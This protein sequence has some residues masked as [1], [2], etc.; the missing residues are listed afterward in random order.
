MTDPTTDLGKRVVIA[1]MQTA[2]SKEFLASIQGG[3]HL[4]VVA[5]EVHQSGSPQNSKLYTLKSGFR[6]GLS[7]TPIR[8][9]D[10]EGTQKLFEYFGPIIQPTVTLHDAIMA[11]RLV[12]YEYKP[13]AVHLTA[14]EVED[15][16]VFTF[17]IRQ[18]MARQ[19]D[20]ADGKKPM[21]ESVKM[22][23]I[24]RSR[25]AKKAKSK[26]LLAS[27]II[28][29]S[30]I[31][32]QRWLVYC[33]DKN[34]LV[35]VISTLKDKNLEPLRYHT[36]MEGDKAATLAHFKTFGGIM[37]SIK[38][39]DEGVDIP[40]VDHALI[41]ASSQ[42]P[43]QFIQRRGRVLRKAKWKN[44]AIVHDAIVVPVNLDEEPELTSLL[45]SE[46]V[47]A[48]EFAKSAINAD[49]AAELRLIAANLGFDPDNSDYA[50]IEEDE[51]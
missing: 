45:K 30:F 24:R 8:Y 4:L 26:V 1:T 41:L 27:A 51:E 19:K 5:D 10:P 37:V 32:G 23:L 13:H 12:E 25:I 43:R 17:R 36:D 44:I 38:C 33:E 2:S 49:A 46:F 28:S 40:T 20:D 39:L 7:A 3:P 18:E 9:G 6:L 29:S 14:E 31:K 21:S 16:K 35:E 34:Q 42:N 11:G 22:L 48:I 47:R 50:G 15:W